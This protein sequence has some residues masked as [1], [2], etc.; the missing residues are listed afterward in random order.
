MKRFLTCILTGS[1]VLALGGCDNVTKQ[2]V[3]AVTGAALGGVL[4]STVGGGHGTTAAIIGGTILGGFLGGAVG[5][6]MDEVDRMKMNQAL[7]TTRTNTTTTWS[8]PDTH[9][10]YA[11]TPVKTYQTAQKQ[12][13]REFKTNVTM[14][15]N[16]ETKSVYGT[17]CRDANGHWNMKS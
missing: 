13:C 3:G 9:N 15:D 7:E 8:N 2:D 11:V 14:A 16:G 5:K 12:P 6:S 4:G 10:T 1:L 17:A